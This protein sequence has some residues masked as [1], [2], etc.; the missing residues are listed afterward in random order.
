MLLNLWILVDSQGRIYYTSAHK[1]DVEEY[2][3]LMDRK[4]LMIKELK[5]GE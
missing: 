3:K 4:D 5:E 1:T 2:Y